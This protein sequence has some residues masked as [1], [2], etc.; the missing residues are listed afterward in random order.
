MSAEYIPRLKIKYKEEVIPHLSTKLK[1]ANSMRMPR[2]VKI[3]LNVGIGDARD[4]A[5]WLKQAVEE[6][7]IISGQKPIITKSKINFPIYEPYRIFI[8]F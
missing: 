8:Q 3:V 2:L 1:I 5:N 4:N 7:S 6:M